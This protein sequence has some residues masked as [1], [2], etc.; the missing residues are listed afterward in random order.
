MTEQGAGTSSCNE[1]RLLATVSREGVGS[2]LSSARFNGSWLTFLPWDL[3]DVLALGW[4]E[5]F[6]RM[7]GS[8]GPRE[9]DW[10]QLPR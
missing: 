2:R 3:Q 1:A 4:G 9:G 8:P 10:P 7:E 6:G 5:E